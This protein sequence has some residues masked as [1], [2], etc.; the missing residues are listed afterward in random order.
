MMNKG[1]LNKL[2]NKK[3]MCKRWNQRKMISEGYRD[4]V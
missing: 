3:E 1:V 2:I 4:H